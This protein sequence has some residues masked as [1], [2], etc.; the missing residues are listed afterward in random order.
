MKAIDILS[1]I[2]EKENKNNCRF[3]DVPCEEVQTE[4]WWWD[5]VG[6]LPPA[7]IA[8]GRYLMAS[9]VGS[10]DLA[11]SICSEL[12]PDVEIECGDSYINL[13]KIED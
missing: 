9:M 11:Y 12:N 8:E 13:Y 2:V 5:N 7:P 10:D 6:A 1:V 4:D 3:L